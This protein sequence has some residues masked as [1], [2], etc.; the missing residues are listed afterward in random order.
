MNLV[1]ILEDLVDDGCGD[2]LGVEKL[3]FIQGDNMGKL[4]ESIKQKAT[5]ARKSENKLFLMMTSAGELL[6][7]VANFFQMKDGKLEYQ[8]KLITLNDFLKER[9]I[10]FN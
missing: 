6:I 3:V 7:E 4:E 2:V 8:P 10:S 5:L 1:L 9:A